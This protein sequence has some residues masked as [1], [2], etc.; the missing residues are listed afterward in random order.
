MQQEKKIVCYAVVF[1]LALWIGGVAYGAIAR[2]RQ[3]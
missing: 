2:R 3:D 1:T